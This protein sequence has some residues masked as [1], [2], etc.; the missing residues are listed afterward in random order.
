MVDTWPTPDGKPFTEQTGEFWDD[1]V[2]RWADGLDE[3]PMPDWLPKDFDDYLYGDHGDYGEIRGP[4]KPGKCVLIKRSGSGDVWGQTCDPI[5]NVP[6]LNRRT[7]LSRHAAKTRLDQLLEWGVTAH[8]ETAS[9]GEWT[10]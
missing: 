5:L 8:L 4:L 2:D 1:I 9:I 6:S 10:R 7:F 3:S